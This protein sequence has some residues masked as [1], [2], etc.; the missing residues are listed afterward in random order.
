MYLIMEHPGRVISRRQYI[1]EV[2]A[3]GRYIRQ[4]RRTVRSIGY[5]PGLDVPRSEASHS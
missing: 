3:P 2:W 1:D 4:E 5:M